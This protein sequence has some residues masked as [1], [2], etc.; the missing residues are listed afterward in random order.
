M[1]KEFQKEELF[2]IMTA[3]S[4]NQTKRVSIVTCFSVIIDGV[5][6]GNRIY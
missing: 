2:V 3:Y 1:L 6:I 5:L 4:K